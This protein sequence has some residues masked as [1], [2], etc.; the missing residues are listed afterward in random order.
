[1]AQSRASEIAQFFRECLKEKGLKVNKVILFGSQARGT[2]TEES[3]IDI[4]IVSEEFRR[5]NIFRRAKLTRDAEIRTI[6]KFMV[7]LDVITMSPEEY[8]NR[9]SLIGEYVREGKIVY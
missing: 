4:V 8:E 7:P 5:K 2:A 6:R 9:T 1:M 3:D